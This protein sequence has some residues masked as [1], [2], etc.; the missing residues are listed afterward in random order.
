MSTQTEHTESKSLLLWRYTDLPATIHLLESKSITLLN[1]ETWDDSNDAFFLNQYKCQEKAE[2]VL[3][4]CFSK[5]LDKYHHWKVFAGGVDGVRI[6][7]DKELLLKDMKNDMKFKSGDVIYKKINEIRNSTQSIHELPFLKRRPFE[8]DKE[9]RIIFVDKNEKVEYKQANIDLNCIRRITLS[10]WMPEAI[11]QSV[12][13]VLK[14]IDGCEG[15][16]IFHSTLINN[17]TWK[18]AGRM[19]GSG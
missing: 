17:Q 19:N 5:A 16:K 7:F 12:K 14:K 11:V 1:P 2:S 18:K 15:L 13:S 3:A 8:D 9:Y 4:L 10:P 6:E